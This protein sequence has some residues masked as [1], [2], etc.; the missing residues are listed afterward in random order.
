MIRCTTAFSQR[1]F[2][3]FPGWSALFPQAGRFSGLVAFFPPGRS[4]SGGLACMDETN[5]VLII[6]RSLFE[7][8]A[9][10]FI[11]SGEGEVWP[12]DVIYLG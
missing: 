2:A 11:L 12:S 7:C 5:S 10:V 3:G 6:L 1:V 8:M 9:E 4:R